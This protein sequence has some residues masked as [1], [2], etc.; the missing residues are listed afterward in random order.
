MPKDPPLRCDIPVSLPEPAG[1]A[2]ESACLLPFIPCSQLGKYQRAGRTPPRRLPD[3]PLR[4]T[5]R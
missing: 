1:R 3:L 4:Q 2:E 5:P